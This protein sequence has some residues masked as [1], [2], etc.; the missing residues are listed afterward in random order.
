MKLLVGLG[1]PG[2]KYAT[3]RHNVG[4]LVLDELARRQS[5]T[6]DRWQEKY[7]GQFVKTP[8]GADSVMLLKPQTM[9][10][11]S[12]QAVRKF[13][14][15]FHL[16]LDEVWVV[17]DD[18]DLPLGQ[19]RIRKS[20]SS[21]GHNGLQSILEALGSANIPRFRL[22]IRGST[23]PMDTAHYVLSPFN[24]DEQLIVT[25]M[26][27]RGA[28]AIESAITNGFRNTTEEPTTLDRVDE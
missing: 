4:W 16:H 21:A 24:N 14:Q 10:N 11:N 9:M 3:T 5:I 20:G 25:E 2:E 22:G 13:K 15:W 23:T 12:G 17:F 6:A 1:N 26:V 28:D 8:L 18:I 27:R 19:I 7:E